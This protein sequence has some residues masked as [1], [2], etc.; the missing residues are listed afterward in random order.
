MNFRCAMQHH[1]YVLARDKQG[2][3]KSCISAE[4]AQTEANAVAECRHIQSAATLVGIVTS[5]I[6]W[7]RYNTGGPWTL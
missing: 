2:S 3:V 1:L 4:V 6:P 7:S 5:A